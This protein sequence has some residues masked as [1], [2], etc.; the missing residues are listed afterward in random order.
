MPLIKCPNCGKM[1]SEHAEKCID[2]GLSMDE[3][4]HREDPGQG[5]IGY[6]K[7][8]A[9]YHKDYGRGIVC[10]PNFIGEGRI[11]KVQFDAGYVRLFKLP[12][13]AL[14]IKEE[15]VPITKTIHRKSHN[16]DNISNIDEGEMALIEYE[17]GLDRYTAEVSIDSIDDNIDYREDYYIEGCFYHEKKMGKDY[18]DDKEFDD[19]DGEDY[20]DSGDDYID[21][22]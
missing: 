16:Y 19:M 17:N 22:F 10:D 15:C 3:I 21:D 4:N 7:V 6:K 9:A 1:I 8:V 11:I 18:F 2:C 14:I 12:D 13:S 5:V 20:M